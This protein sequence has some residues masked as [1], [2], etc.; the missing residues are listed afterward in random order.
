MVVDFNSQGQVV[1][2]N[3]ND[4]RLYFRVDDASAF[5]VKAA[6][7]YSIPKVEENIDA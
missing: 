5:M 2:R 1:Q 7:G 6:E 3:W 4:M